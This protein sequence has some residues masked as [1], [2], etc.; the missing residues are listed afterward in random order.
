MATSAK[1][2]INDLY[3]VRDKAEIV[4]GEIVVISPNRGPSRNGGRGSST[5][6]FREYQR[7]VGGGFAYPDGV[8]FVV[9]LPNRKSFRSNAAFHSQ[10]Q[11]TIKLVQGAPVFAV[12][13]RREEDYG[14]AAEQEMARKRADYFAART[15]VVWDVDL[16]GSE[17]IRSYQAGGATPRVFRRSDLADA[18]P[19]LPGWRFSESTSSSSPLRSPSGPGAASSHPVRTE[20]QLPVVSRS[21]QSPV[22]RRFVC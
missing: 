4:D 15:L 19:A 11:P 5:Q 17:T 13:V 12:E 20:E 8:G 10:P 7:S 18:E 14:P 6:V 16:Q 22:P 9:D 1:A 3:R 2:T 21:L